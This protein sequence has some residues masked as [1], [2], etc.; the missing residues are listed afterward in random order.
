MPLLS[1]DPAERTKALPL[2]AVLDKP[3]QDARDELQPRIDY[4]ASRSV[5]NNDKDYYKFPHFNDDYVLS[6][7]ERFTKLKLKYSIYPRSIAAPGQ[8]LGSEEEIGGRKRYYHQRPFAERIQLWAEPKENDD[9]FLEMAWHWL[10]PFRPA[11]NVKANVADPVLGRDIRVRS[12]RCA[13]RSTHTRPDARPSPRS[14][15]DSW[16]TSHC[17]WQLIP[18]RRRP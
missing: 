12:P 4:L 2:I 14:G 3:M 7:V 1:E 16:L 10:H 13:R 17:E 8:P 6:E 9:K 15:R 18:S 5:K 11:L